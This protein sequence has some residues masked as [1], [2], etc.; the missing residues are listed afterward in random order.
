MKKHLLSIIAI[1]VGLAVFGAQAAE[2]TPA[3]VPT[4][5]KLTKEER[6]EATAKRRADMTAATKKGEAPK[7]VESTQDKPAAATG[8]RAERKAARAKQRAE[9]AKASK[10]GKLPVTTEA[11]T[12]TKK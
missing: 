3:P 6:A 4:G 1:T 9:M 7:T 11:G 8:T 12:E 10:E 5:P 2:G